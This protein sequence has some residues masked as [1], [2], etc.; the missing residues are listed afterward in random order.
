MHLFVT[1]VKTSVLKVLQLSV[2]SLIKGTVG[3][4]TKA[5]A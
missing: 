1:T 3:Q 2:P 4:P 5:T